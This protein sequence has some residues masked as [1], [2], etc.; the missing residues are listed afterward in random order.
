MNASPTHYELEPIEWTAP[1]WMPIPKPDATDLPPEDGWQLWDLA[2]RL[3][4]T[5]Q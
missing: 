4:D 2:V 5:R 1:L 3:Q